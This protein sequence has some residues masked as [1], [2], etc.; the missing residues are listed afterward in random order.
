MVHGPDKNGEH[1]FAFDSYRIV[2]IDEN[3]RI[4]G[5]FGGG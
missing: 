1:Y 5:T 4:V 3:W 2:E